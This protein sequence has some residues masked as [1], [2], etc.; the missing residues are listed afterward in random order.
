VWEEDTRR[1]KK[2][3]QWCGLFM[4][5]SKPLVFAFNGSERDNNLRREKSGK[6]GFP[7]FE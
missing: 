3:S 5:I 6:K 1:K 7:L 2:F 4:S